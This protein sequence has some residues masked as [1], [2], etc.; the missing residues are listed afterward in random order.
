MPKG[1]PSEKSAGRSIQQPHWTLIT[2]L[3]RALALCAFVLGVIGAFLPIVPTAPFLLVSAWAASKG[4]PQFERWLL[5]HRFFGPPILRW[6]ANGAISRS[7]KWVA[8]TMMLGSALLLQLFVAVP[9]GVR[10]G[11]PLFLGAVAIWLWLR[12]EQ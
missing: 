3:W 9:L 7:A 8:S 12:P 5:A 4:W 1:K 10:V 2:L 11:V 6:R